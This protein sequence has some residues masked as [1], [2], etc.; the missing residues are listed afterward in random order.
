MSAMSEQVLDSPS[1]HASRPQRVLACVLC[2]Q[3]KIKCIRRFPC[4]NCIKAGATCVPGS[5]NPRRRRRF[6]ERELLVRIR[7]YEDLLRENKI[8]F[9]P[10]HKDFPS[11][12]AASRDA[13]AANESDGEPPSHDGPHPPAGVNSER[14]H[15]GKNLWHT[16]VQGVLP[17]LIQATRSSA[18]MSAIVPTL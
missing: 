1:S 16:M 9:D 17:H 4:P 11:E 15:H 14:G 13:E 3:R 7:E 12:Y 5:V 10:L 2:Q 8:R 18:D 6:P